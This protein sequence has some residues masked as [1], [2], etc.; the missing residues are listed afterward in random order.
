M[1]TTSHV[2]IDNRDMLARVPAWITSTRAET[3]EDVAFLSGAALN[4]L[5]LV[6]GRANVPHALLRDRMALRAAEACVA[7]SG[8]QERAGSCAMRFIFCAPVIYLVGGRNLSGL[9]ARGG[10]TGFGQGAAPVFTRDR[11]RPDRRGA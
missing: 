10:A 3:L 8:R 1:I 2:P 7:F 9:A 4:H 5:H 11:R 6:L